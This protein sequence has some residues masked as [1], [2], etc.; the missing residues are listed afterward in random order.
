MTTTT[1]GAQFSEFSAPGLS[2]EED[3]QLLVREDLGP[4]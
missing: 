3:H 1:S 2:K 4:R